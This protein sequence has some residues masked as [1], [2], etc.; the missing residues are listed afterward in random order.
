MDIQLPVM[1]GIQATKEIRRLEKS[2]NVGVYPSTPPISTERLSEPFSTISTPWGSAVSVFSTSHRSPVIIVA[3]TASSL[4]SDRHAALAAGCN[5]FLTKPVSLVWLEK[6][7]IEWGCMQ[8]LIDF[9]GYKRWKAADQ[10][11]AGNGATN[12]TTTAASGSSG[13]GHSTSS[14]SEKLSQDRSKPLNGDYALTAS[15]SMTAAL[16]ATGQENAQAVASRLRIDT[17]ARRRAE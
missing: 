6:K 4:Q 15:S 12:S 9:E 14:L 5:D 8:A 11:A 1:D 3:L 13:S 2:N 17:K 7:I 16:S 10:S